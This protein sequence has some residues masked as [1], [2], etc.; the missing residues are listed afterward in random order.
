MVAA[1]KINGANEKILITGGVR[2]HWDRLT[3]ISLKKISSN[4]N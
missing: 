3:E 1:L 2:I 4:F